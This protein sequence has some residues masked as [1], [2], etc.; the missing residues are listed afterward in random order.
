MGLDTTHGCW[1]APYSAFLRWRSE[2]A[3]A[4]GYEI[5]GQGQYVLPWD[6]FKP[7]HY[8]GEWNGFVPGD[9]P[10][11]YLLVHSDCDGVIHPGQGIHIAARLKQLLPLLDES[12]S[13][14]NIMS[15]RQR[16]QRFIDGLTA[17]AKAGEDVEFH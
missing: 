17:A 2:L 16:T 10:L 1:H 14:G 7:E 4:A 13:A 8:Q 15:T 11:L 6:E 12:S 3:R 9:D 5:D